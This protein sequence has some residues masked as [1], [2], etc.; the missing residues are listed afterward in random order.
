MRKSALV[1]LDLP[2]LCSCTQYPACTGE[3]FSDMF[4]GQEDEFDGQEDDDEADE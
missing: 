3:G 2:V 1:C 4:D